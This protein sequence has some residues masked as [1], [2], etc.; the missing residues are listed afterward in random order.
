MRAFYSNIYQAN[1][2]KNTENLYLNRILLKNQENNLSA[3]DSTLFYLFSIIQ[4]LT[5][6][7]V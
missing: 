1:L 3:N 7:G 6:Q 2:I 5:V 4:K